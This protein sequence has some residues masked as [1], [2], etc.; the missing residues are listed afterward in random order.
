MRIAPKVMADSLTHQD[1][2]LGATPWKFSRVTWD[3][4][5]TPAS[6]NNLV[7]GSVILSGTN[8]PQTVTADLGRS[9]ALKSFQDTFAE[10]QIKSIGFKVEGSAD[11]QDWTVLLDQTKPGEAAVPRLNKSADVGSTTD[12]V[13]F[14]E[15]TVSASIG[16]SLSGRYRFVRLTMTECDG[17]KPPAKHAL[18]IFGGPDEKTS[19]ADYAKPDFDD[20]NWQTVGLPN[21]FNDQDTYLDAN[22]ARMWRGVV[23][24]RT[25]LNI[26]KSDLGKRHIIEF[27]GVTMAAAVYVNDK[28]QPGHS[29]VKQTGDVTHVGQFLP[30]AVDISDAL[31]AGDNVIA[32]R[33]SNL[34]NT[35]YTGPGFEDY[36]GFGM[37]WGGIVN[38]VHLHVTSP[39]FIPL[40]AATEDGVWGTYTGVVA[41][42][43]ARAEV[44]AITRVK[45]TTPTEQTVTVTTTFISP[46]GAKVLSLK[47]TRTIAAGTYGEFD[48]LGSITNPVLWYPNNSPYGKPQLHRVVREVAIAGKIVDSQ[49]A[50]CGLRVI[51]WTGDYCLI[52]GRKHLLFGYGSRNIYPALGQA[53]PAA[54]QWQDIALIAQSGGNCLRIGHLPTTQ[55]IWTLAMLTACSSCRKAVTMNG[56]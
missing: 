47:N 22:E 8:L 49:E 46:S 2:D 20:S 32:V 5:A 52:N 27:E 51:D 38:P 31:H 48:Q 23:W 12:T 43:D 4:R 24:Y 39:I 1:I 15:K 18:E 17:G 35:F 36:A 37:N 45:N 53:V 21:C 44:R 50:K 28:F 11:G 42:D 56:R 14:V 25:H 26:Q 34:G 54:L 19:D 6:Q 9:V 41:A 10:I 29:S 55:T 13:G 30:F 33:V 7:T 3:T 40:N 16:D